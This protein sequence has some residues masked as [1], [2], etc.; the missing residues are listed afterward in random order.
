MSRPPSRSLPVFEALFDA[1]R[2]ADA[3]KALARALVEPAQKR[4]YRF[5]DEALVGEM[6]AAV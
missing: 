2:V 1:P 4:G 3:G 5:E 6:V